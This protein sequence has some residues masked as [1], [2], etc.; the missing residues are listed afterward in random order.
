LN[1]LDAAGVLD[2]SDFAGSEDLTSFGYFNNAFDTKT[3]GIDIVAQTNLNLMG[4]DTDIAFA[5]NWTDTE[6]SN[7]K[8]S[9]GTGT[10][11]Y[12]RERQLEENLPSVRGS[13]TA[14]HTQGPWRGLVRVNY[15]GS[16]FECHLDAVGSDSIG[17]CDLPIDAGDEIT[18]DLEGA[19]R[20]GG[21]WEILIG[22]RNAFDS[23][24]DANP[25][26][27][28]VGAQYPVTA[29]NGFN[30]GS[31]YLGLRADF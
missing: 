23:T 24:P 13:I 30:G 22:A 14:N 8:L 29:P 28:I 26:A 25:Y 15:F 5:L 20:I 19:Y 18:V 21:S 27:G 4:G 10:L 1:L 31:Y 7:G 2:A 11:S 9:D 12:T 3:Q 6:V 16:F 17:T